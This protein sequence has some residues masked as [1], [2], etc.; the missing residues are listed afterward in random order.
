M[1][2]VNL[3]QIPCD[4]TILFVPRVHIKGTNLVI[5]NSVAEQVEWEHRIFFTDYGVF[6]FNQADDAVTIQ[7]SSLPQDWINV[8]P[9]AFQLETSKNSLDPRANL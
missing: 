5:L 1:C 6:I 2:S 4:Y 3:N 7:M 9:F 8:N